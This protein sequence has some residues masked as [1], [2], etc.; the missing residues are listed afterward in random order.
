MDIIYIGILIILLMLFWKEYKISLLTRIVWSLILINDF[1]DKDKE[2]IVRPAL[3]NM[4][5]AS[6]KSS[7]NL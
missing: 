7:T 4:V 2:E 3:V 6:K 1:I 5:V